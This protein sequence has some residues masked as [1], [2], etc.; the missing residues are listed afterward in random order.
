MQFHSFAFGWPVIAA[1]VFEETLFSPLCNLGSFVVNQLTVYMWVYFWALYSVLWSLFLCQYH[2]ALITIA[3]P[4]KALAL[5]ATRAR[6]SG[7]VP[8]VIVANI[9]QGSR[10]VY[11]LLS[12]RYWWALARQ[13]GTW[14]GIHCPLFP[15]C[16]PVGL[17]M[18]VEPGAGP[19]GRAAGQ[20]DRLFSQNDRV[21]VCCVYSYLGM[22]A[23]QELSLQLLQS[24]GTQKPNPPS[25]PEPGDQDASTGQQLQ[26]PGH[27]T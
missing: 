5:L 4:L 20:A 11:N 16:T 21:S 18:W 23:C 2:T 22:V 25:P 3:L 10:W 19:S 7:I 13:R 26:K 17:E 24:C 15:E 14:D 1:P 8:W 6:P 9:N 27:E 12:G